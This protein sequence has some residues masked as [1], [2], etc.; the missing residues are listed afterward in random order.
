MPDILQLY[1]LLYKNNQCIPVI[2]KVHS[3]QLVTIS[4]ND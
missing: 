2:L 1:K 4:Y 3:T